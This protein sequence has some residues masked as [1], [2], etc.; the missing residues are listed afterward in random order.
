[1]PLFYPVYTFAVDRQVQGIRVGPLFSMSD[2][3]AHVGEWYLFVESDTGTD[4]LTPTP[5]Q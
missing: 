1:L 3:Y 5:E 4:E 2:R